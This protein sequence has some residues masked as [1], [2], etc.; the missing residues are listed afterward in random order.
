MARQASFEELAD[1]LQTVRE[2]KLWVTRA[3]PSFFMS[4]GLAFVANL[5]YKN[6]KRLV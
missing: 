3:D 2:G 1:E 4:G 6:L 5:V